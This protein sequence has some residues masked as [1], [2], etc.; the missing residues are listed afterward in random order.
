MV[1]TGKI[2]TLKEIGLQ[3]TLCS[4]RSHGEDP[5]YRYITI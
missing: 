1:V 5:V 2:E 4:V 3:A